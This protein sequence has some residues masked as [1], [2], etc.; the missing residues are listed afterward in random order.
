MRDGQVYAMPTTKLTDARITPVWNQQRSFRL[1]RAEAIAKAKSNSMTGMP[2]VVTLYELGGGNGFRAIIDG[3]HRVG[4][5]RLLLRGADSSSPWSRVL[6][7]VFPLQNEAQAEALFTEINSAQPVQMV[8][9]PASA[10]GAAPADRKCLEAGVALMVAQFGSTMF[11]PSVQC[12]APHMNGDRLR[13]MLFQRDVMTAHGLRTPEQLHAWLL[14]RNAELAS[15]TDEAWAARMPV[16]RS[17][18]FDSAFSKALAKAR[19]NGFF[20]G[21][22]WR[23]LDE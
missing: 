16:K 10:G 23:W 12:K 3:Q 6:V 21:M 15:L 4:A 17:A 22:D 5:L 1:E 9:M 7:E 18:S 11:K 8:D 19:D 13:D 20:L 2:G 14:A